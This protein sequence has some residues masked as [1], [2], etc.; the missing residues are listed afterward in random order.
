MALLR[1]KLDRAGRLTRLRQYTVLL[2]PLNGHQVGPCR[3]LCE[4]VGE[5]GVCGRPA[6]H[7]MVGRTQAAIASHVDSEE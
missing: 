6:P 1:P 3:A 4:P 5:N 2:C 7:L